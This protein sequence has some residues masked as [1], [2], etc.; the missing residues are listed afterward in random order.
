M[1]IAN[2]TK[3]E[4]TKKSYKKTAK[5]LFKQYSKQSGV[6]VSPINLGNFIEWLYSKCPGWSKNTLKQY[7]AALVYYCQSRNMDSQAELIRRVPLDNCKKSSNKLKATQK[8]TAAKK[9]KKV[10]G[11]VLSKLSKKID[12]MKSYWSERALIYLQAG[13]L[14]GL[15]PSE[16][17]GVGFKVDFGVLVTMVVKN[18]KNSN[19]RSHGD[20]RT[21]ELDA[22]NED[23]IEIIK[24]QIAYTKEPRDRDGDLIN[25]ENYYERCRRALYRV[26]RI[27]FPNRSKTVCLYSAR[28][29]FAAN[30]KKAGTP[31]NVIAALMGHAVDTT[32]HRHYAK[33]RSGRAHA[34]LPNARMDEVMRVREKYQ[35]YYGPRKNIRFG[36]S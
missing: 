26:Y 3:N 25:F 4:K 16:W 6:R 1:F 18:G 15:R 5:R 13:I 21:L 17:N 8:K 34:R 32:A 2:P 9:E 19:G 29:Q 23:E 11:E 20:Y 30:L 27:V 31:P 24:K 36:L 33:G 35:P 14:T 22:L 10:D 12:G 7:R 28:H